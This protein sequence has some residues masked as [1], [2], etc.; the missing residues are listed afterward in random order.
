MAGQEPYPDIPEKTSPFQAHQIVCDDLIEFVAE[1][2]AR[3]LK[4][5]QIKRL[6]YQVIGGKCN[7]ATTEKLLG[8]ARALNQERAGLSMQ[9]ETADAVAFLKE[10][11]ADDEVSVGDKLRAQEQLAKMIGIGQFGSTTP[12]TDLERARKMRT[13]M[14]QMENKTT[15]PKDDATAES[16]ISA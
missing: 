12:L 7:R 3:R 4:K 16:D 8:K 15:G 6:V 5:G 1:C 13:L 11:I 10:V 2:L 9:E 14:K